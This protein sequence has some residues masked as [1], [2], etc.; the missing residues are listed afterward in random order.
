MVG[1][2]TS[3]LDNNQLR[4]RILLQ[5]PGS[6]VSHVISKSYTLAEAEMDWEYVERVLSPKLGGF[7]GGRDLRDFVVV[8]R[9]GGGGGGGGGGG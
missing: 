5:P 3:V 2:I 4:Y 7:E 6:E 8:R 9:R 1:T